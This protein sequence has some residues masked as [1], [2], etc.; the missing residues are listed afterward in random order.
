MNRTQRIQ[1]CA[2]QD[3]AKW[4]ALFNR[5]QQQSRRR[6]LLALKAI[7]DG[8][9]MIEVCRSQHVQR[10]TLEK[11]LDAYL[12]GG[13]KALLAPQRR[14]RP[15]TLDPRRRRILRHVLLHKTPAD[16]GID[17]Y[18]W[19]A[20]LVRE[21][22]QKK[23]GVT[24]GNTRLYEIFDELG[25]SHQRAH[26]DYGPALPGQRAEFVRELE[27]K[28]PKRPPAPPSSPLTSSL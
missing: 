27:K 11:W 19:T 8:Q 7:W 28:R 2:P 23:W 16:Y 25:L 17:R 20:P 1:R 21:W 5:H 26:R 12:H 9:S 24:L 3:R 4:Q 13:F 22:L 10:K 6:R 15:Q 18:P 14:P